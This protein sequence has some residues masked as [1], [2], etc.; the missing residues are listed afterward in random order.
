MQYRYLEKYYKEIHE[1]D[2]K[3]SR[4]LLEE[5]TLRLRNK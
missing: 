3:K 4:K 1:T 5:M 2:K